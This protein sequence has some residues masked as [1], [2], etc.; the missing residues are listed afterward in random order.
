MITDIVVKSW[1]NKD[2]R[3]FDVEYQFCSKYIRAM[4]IILEHIGGG[5]VE[6]TIPEVNPTTVSIA[7]SNLLAERLKERGFTVIHNA[8]AAQVFVVL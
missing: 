2:P 7:S 1:N 6:V 3:N 8:A 5:K 4:N